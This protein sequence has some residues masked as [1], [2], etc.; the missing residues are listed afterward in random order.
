MILYGVYAGVG[1]GRDAMPPPR[2]L[3]SDSAMAPYVMVH[4]TSVIG[5]VAL[6]VA[7]V[8]IQAN[9]VMKG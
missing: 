7:V 3:P 1:T 4:F 2:E 8:G 6:A 5:L 9:S